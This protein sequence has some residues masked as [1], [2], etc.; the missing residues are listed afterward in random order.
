MV[1]CLLI[2]NCCNYIATKGYVYLSFAALALFM[3]LLRILNLYYSWPYFSHTPYIFSSDLYTS[4][5]IFRSFGDFCLNILALSWF[6]CFVYRYRDKLLLRRIH[7]KLTGYVIVIGS[8]ILLIAIS[9][10]L[11]RHFYELAINSKINFDVN[12]V[13]DLSRY[14]ALGI[15]MLCFAYLI[16]YLMVDICITLCNRT[17]I[18]VLHQLAVLAGGVLITTA[19]SVVNGDEFTFFYIL[20]SIWV[21]I[22]GYSFRTP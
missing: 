22:R 13:L 10:T 2:H 11:L 4:G 17:D 7:N 16:F 5:G 15:L 20:S 19:I 12:N 9:A 21:I 6:M 8:V 14:S 18:P 1:L 3:V